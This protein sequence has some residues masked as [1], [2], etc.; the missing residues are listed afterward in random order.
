MSHFETALLMT[1]RLLY[2]VADQPPGWYGETPA[3]VIVE[4]RNSTQGSV[5]D[6]S[7]KKTDGVPVELTYPDGRRKRRHV[8]ENF[9]VEAV[10][11]ILA[12]TATTN[13]KTC[14]RCHHSLSVTEFDPRPELVDGLRSEC[15]DCHRDDSR[16]ALR[17]KYQ[18]E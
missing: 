1:T 16:R 14:H 15:K 11:A 4:R 7:K 8:H 6:G 13:V 9:E 18:D 3:G 5:R 10:D 12:L 17:K 2:R